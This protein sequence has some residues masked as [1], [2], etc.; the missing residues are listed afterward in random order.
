M[1]IL[2]Y[3]RNIGLY[4]GNP[5]RIYGG[6]RLTGRIGEWDLGLLDMQTAKFEDLSGREFWDSQDKAKNFKPEFI[7]G[8]DNYIQNRS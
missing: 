2:F 5:V 1:T 8:R 7:S 4:N 3:S 6:L